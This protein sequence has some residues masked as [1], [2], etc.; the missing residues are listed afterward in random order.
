MNIAT[1]N[2]KAIWKDRDYKLDMLVQN[3]NT[4]DISI[5]GIS[6]THWDKN[7]EE[8]F[9]HNGFAIFQSCRQDGIHRQG[10]AIAL[11]KELL[12]GV[13][14]ID[15]IAPDMMSITVHTKDES[16][17]IYQIYAPDSSHSDE[18]VDCFY[19]KL[20]Q[21]IDQ[22]PR[23][24]RLILLGDFNAKVGTDYQDTM[25]D[26]VGKFGLGKTNDR[27]WKLLEFCAINNLVIT[28]TLFNHSPMRRVTWVSPGG[29][30]KNQ[31]DYIIADRDLKGTF[32]NSRS[33]HSADIG[34][35]HSLV[36]AKLNM[37]IP[38]FRRPT[39][40]PKRFDVEK[41]R[42]SEIAASFQVRVGG[43]FEPLL[44]MGDIEIDELYLKFQEATNKATKEIVGYK[45]HKKVEGLPPE[46]ENACKERR[47]ARVE[48]L[49][50]PANTSIKEKY[51]EQNIHVKA[52]IKKHKH[53]ALKAKV[54]QM[55][56][57][58][59]NNNSYNLFKTVR[60]LEN[61]QKK[62]LNV[63]QD[64]NG[65]KHTNPEE[66]L[67][68]WEEHFNTHLNKE[69]PRNAQALDQLPDPPVDA[70]R[71]PPIT[72][73]E[74]TEAV[75]RMLRRKAPGIDAIT[76]EVLLAGGDPMLDM[77]FLIFSKVWS[78]EKPPKEW[79]KMLVTPIH[80]KDSK[81]N[82]VNFR[83]IALLSIPGKVF[84]RILLMR[85]TNRTEAFLRE[86]QFG[87]RRN[88]GTVDAIFVVRQIMEKARERRVNLHFHFIDFK[89]AFDTVW[90]NA[91][92][93]MLR[94]I[95][96]DGKIINIVEE[97]YKNTKCA[98]TINGQITNWFNV[99]V[100]VRQGCLL[101]PVFFNIF[102][103][104]VI[105]ELKS[106]DPTFE[107]HDEMSLEERYA[108]DTT[109]ISAIF[110]KLSLSTR[111]LEMACKKWGMKVNASKCNVISDD[112]ECIL[113]DGEAVDK[114]DEFI[115]LGSIVPGTTNDIKRRVGLAAS[116]FGRLRK[117]VWNNP[118]ISL[119]LKVRLYKALILPIATYA[120]ET[121]TLKKSDEQ[122]LLVFE[123]RCLRAILRVTRRD[124]IRNEVIR[125]RLGV[126]STIIDAIR[127]RRM[128]WFGH[129]IRRPSHSMV[130]VAYRTDFDNP[131]PRGRPPKRWKDQIMHDS[132]ITLM[133]AEMEALDR[134][135]WKD[136]IK[137]SK[138][139]VPVLST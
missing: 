69:F 91:L 48:M 121:W 13:E 137:R 129:V 15:L 118:D 27:G 82:P 2:V 57:D 30:Y 135:K 83:A 45:K 125:N 78:E 115:F 68:I 53:N 123:M 77:L 6:E 76:T 131:R 8:M 18:E 120:C 29:E 42:N 90:R 138:G 105:D 98:V 59:V 54:K 33:Y 103:E 56:K 47:K 3:I 50:N 4:L 100:G 134:G 104:F 74:L 26:V 124:R 128:G 60:E 84:L 73:E 114:V 106:L 85:M 75:K 39:A 127:S 122:L 36:M 66:V 81:I 37:N 92:W 112:H 62:T 19:D 24:S 5:V 72:R 25:T 136:R 21:K 113:I 96:V 101:S 133:E 107:L 58:Y 9:E 44:Q 10:V 132:G 23:K 126:E 93:K 61:K 110:R 94:A 11:R 80:K 95:G 97:L 117:T 40:L 119:K 17:V 139:P 46:I 70:D 87:F 109:L 108:D 16:Y 64:K 116:A 63:V 41:L 130:S 31:I 52:E 38:K 79:S 20:Q 1:W 51:R 111:E 28:N 34:S 49:N 102:L 32:K 65:I 22:R 71:G 43:Y 99:K 89:A 67:K 7:E 35:D 88:R 86:S 14:A 12:P 55:E